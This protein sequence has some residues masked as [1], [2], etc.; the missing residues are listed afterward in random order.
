MLFGSDAFEVVGDV[1]RAVVAAQRS[2]LIEYGLLD[3]GWRVAA[4]DT[5]SSLASFDERLAQTAEK[6]GLPVLCR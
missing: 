3:L 4:E 2:A 5:A 6:R 1:V